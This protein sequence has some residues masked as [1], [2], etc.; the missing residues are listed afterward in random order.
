MTVPTYWLAAAMAL[1]CFA[2]LALARLSWRLPGF[3]G[4][5]SQLLSLLSIAWWTAMV[6]I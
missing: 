4:Q 5:R 1:A 6:T 3:P 2:A